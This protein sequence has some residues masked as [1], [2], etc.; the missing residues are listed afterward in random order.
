[1][2]RLSDAQLDQVFRAARPLPVRD[3]DAFLQM[4]ADRLCG[5]PEPG[6][7]QVFRVVAE[8]QRRFHHPPLGTD[9]DGHERNPPRGAKWA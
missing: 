7:G 1:M 8:V 5:C 4:I 9:E 2:L 6:D 3:R